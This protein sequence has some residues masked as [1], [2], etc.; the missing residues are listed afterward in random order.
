MLYEN[1]CAHIIIDIF[2][3]EKVIEAKSTIVTDFCQNLASNI[4][5]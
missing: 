4:S 2:L 5:K 1:N 3:R